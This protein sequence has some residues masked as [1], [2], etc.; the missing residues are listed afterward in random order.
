MLSLLEELEPKF[1]KVFQKNVAMEEVTA[2]SLQLSSNAA[3]VLTNRHIYLLYKKI[4][5]VVCKKVKLND[6]KNVNFKNQFNVQTQNGKFS[7]EVKRKKR[8]LAR[9]AVRKIRERCAE[10]A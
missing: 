8:S 4:F 6:V 9:K 10:S 2:M 7:L 3:V 1:R 5:W